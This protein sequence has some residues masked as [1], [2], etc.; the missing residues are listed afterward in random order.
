[1]SERAYAQPYRTADSQNPVSFIA[2]MTDGSV[3]SKFRALTPQALRPFVSLLK[4][5]AWLQ[6]HV[7]N[8]AK[9]LKG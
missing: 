4:T 5:E 6:E 9:L 8:G 2:F 3:H 7:R 1:M